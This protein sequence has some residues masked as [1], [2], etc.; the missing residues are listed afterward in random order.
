[1]P[2]PPRVSPGPLE[3]ELTG[4][5]PGPCEFSLAGAVPRMALVVAGILNLMPRCSSER[6]QQ[7]R[8][9]AV[10][11]PFHQVLLQMHHR[12]VH[13]LTE[14]P[15]GGLQSQQAAADDHGS[16][17]GAGRLEHPVHVLEIAEG[18]HA[19]TDRAPA[20]AE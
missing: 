9:G 17:V 16:R 12:D 19:R 5:S 20:R 4:A 6:L 14:Q 7:L 18:D 13:A 1:M 2:S 15:V 11:L 10:E 3:P 8:G